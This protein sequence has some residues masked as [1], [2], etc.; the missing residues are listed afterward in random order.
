[1]SL[2][3]TSQQ[4]VHF[5]LGNMAFI[6][7]RWVKLLHTVTFKQELLLLLRVEQ[8]INLSVK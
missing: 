5:L 3:L 4:L 8:Q 6:I 1:M 2:H 7:S